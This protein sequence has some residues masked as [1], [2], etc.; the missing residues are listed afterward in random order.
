LNFAVI[1]FAFLSG[2]LLHPT[3]AEQFEGKK[4]VAANGFQT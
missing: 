1:S 2:C 3:L 4:A